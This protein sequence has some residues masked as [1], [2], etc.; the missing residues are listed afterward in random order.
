[1]HILYLNFKRTWHHLTERLC[2]SN[3]KQIE[4]AIMA[5]SFFVIVVKYTISHQL[6]SATERNTDHFN[7]FEVYSSVVL[8][9]LTVLHWRDF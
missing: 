5:R 7:H 4:E 6:C 9:A 8:S 1:M 3:F 2:D